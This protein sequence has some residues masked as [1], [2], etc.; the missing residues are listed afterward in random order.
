MITKKV[1]FL[2][3]GNMG[4]A[5]AQRIALNNSFVVHVSDKDKAKATAFADSHGAKTAETAEICKECGFIFLAVKPQVMPSL[6]KEISPILDDRQDS[7]CIVSMAAGWSIE[8]LSGYIGNG[9]PVIRIMPNTPTAV[10]EGMIVYS[11]NAASEKYEQVFREMMRTC[12]IIEHVDESKIDAVTSISGCGPAYVYMF[13]NAMA[14]AGVSLGLTRSLAQE[15]AAQTLLGS[16]KMIQT[17]DKHPMTL[18]DEVC[19][20][21]GST[22]QGVLALENNGFN[23]AVEKAVIAG[24]EK[25]VKLGK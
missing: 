6:L 11:F 23:N 2:G 1:G 14:D 8:K 13:I 21:G 4:G 12:G 25:T 20:P 19:S 17:S 5:I 15:L 24:Y 22:I 9:F 7:C 16:A 10:G 18:K 3:C